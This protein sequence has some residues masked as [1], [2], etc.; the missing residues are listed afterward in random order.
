MDEIN[1]KILD[2]F[3]MSV[4]GRRGGRRAERAR[5]AAVSCSAAALAAAFDF[6][7]GVQ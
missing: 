4:E 7:N 1:Y 3:V 2:L 5:F 6:T